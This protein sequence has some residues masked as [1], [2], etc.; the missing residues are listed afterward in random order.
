MMYTKIIY[1]YIYIYITRPSKRNK[2]Y[3][4]LFLFYFD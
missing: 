3:N 4:K 1:L 2:K